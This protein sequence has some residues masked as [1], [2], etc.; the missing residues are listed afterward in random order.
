MF[1]AGIAAKA[2][3]REAGKALIDY[4]ASTKVREA[5]VAA[6]LEPLDR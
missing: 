4:L 5:I 3:Q 6:G 2:V 1:S